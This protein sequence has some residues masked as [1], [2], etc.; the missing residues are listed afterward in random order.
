MIALAALLAEKDFDPWLNC[1]A[2]RELLV[3]APEDAL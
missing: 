1:A 3:P 2:G